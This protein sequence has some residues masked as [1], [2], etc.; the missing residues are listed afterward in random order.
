MAAMAIPTEATNR[1]E[2]GK[3]VAVGVFD[4]FTVKETVSLK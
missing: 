4:V 2:A 3:G 1:S